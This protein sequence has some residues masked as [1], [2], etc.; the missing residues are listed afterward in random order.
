MFERGLPH[1]HDE[2]MEKSCTEYILETYKKRKDEWNGDILKEYFKE[3]FEDF[4][5]EMFKN[6]PRTLRRDL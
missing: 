2:D 6:L 3:D 1:P 4:P 5:L